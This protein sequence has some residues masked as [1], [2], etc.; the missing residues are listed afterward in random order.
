MDGPGWV[1]GSKMLLSFF[2]AQKVPI[3]MM[4]RR[5]DEVI[6]FMAFWLLTAAPDE[7]SGRRKV[8]GRLMVVSDGSRWWVWDHFSI[9]ESYRAHETL[10]SYSLSVCLQMM[11]IVSISSFRF[12]F[13][14]STRAKKKILVFYSCSAHLITDDGDHDHRRKSP[15]Y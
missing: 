12:F 15:F 13:I 11:R 1:I 2:G 14:W 4:R 9:S 3:L 10:Q 7:S 5:G 6:I 8:G